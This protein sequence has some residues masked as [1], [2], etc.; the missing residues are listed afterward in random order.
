MD[1]PSPADRLNY[2][3]EPT[4]EAKIIT[5]QKLKPSVTPRTFRR[6]FTPRKCLQDGPQKRNRNSLAELTPSVV[7]SRKGTHQAKTPARRLF[8]VDNASSISP[9]TALWE[10]TKSSPIWSRGECDPSPLKRAKFRHDDDLDHK[11][12]LD[13]DLESSDDEEGDKP[14]EPSFAPTIRT[15]HYRS[16]LGDGLRRQLG[17]SSTPLQKPTFSVDPR[18]ETARYYSVPDDV[19]LCHTLPNVPPRSVMPFCSAACNTNSLVAIGDEDGVVRILETSASAA[20]QFPDPLLSFRAHNNAL[21][22]LEFSKD[23]RLLATA[24]GDQSCQ[25]ID[26]LS[27]KAIYMLK[28]HTSSAKQVRFQPGSNDSVIATSSRDGSIQIWDLRCSSRSNPANRVLVSFNGIEEDQVTTTIGSPIRYANRIN[29]IDDAHY[30]APSS[31]LTTNNPNNPL[32]LS[33]P[34]KNTD[35]RI[36]TLQ[37]R[38]EPSVT[39]LSF[40]SPCNPHILLSGSDSQATIKLWDTRMNHNHRHQAT[41]LS[42]TELPLPHSR[43]RHFG[44]TSMAISADF[45]RLYTLCKDNS[46]YVYSTSHLLLG[47]SNHNQLSSSQYT[48]PRRSTTEPQYHGAGPLYSFQ[49]PKISISSFYVK[50]AL[51]APQATGGISEMLAVGSSEACAILFPTDESTFLHK[52]KHPHR[53]THPSQTQ[54]QLQPIPTFRDKSLSPSTTTTNPI[55]IFTHGTALVR[56][57]DK[58]V[59]SLCWTSEGDLVT[60]GDDTRCRVWRGGS[61]GG[62]GDGDVARDIRLGGDRE[63][64]RWG[65]GWAEVDGEWDEDDG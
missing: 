51:R 29:F 6:F 56:G 11:L 2:I 24:S 18:Y 48:P 53:H 14:Q 47:G 49:H 7:N 4:P 44:L 36:S 16:S 20:R 54:P 55:P 41:P 46:I 26:M 9:E 37:S 10:Q 60:L 1:L 23:D 38:S 13:L 31:L 19:F 63:G 32:S 57:H 35:R 30:T 27:Q 45:S 15:S 62:N 5:K 12:D 34:T 50:L 17:L 58:E 25:I 39:A 43:Y 59:T 33:L 28:G 8:D 64:R 61:G 52:Q 65:H 3:R 42:T 22:D 21:L 40:L